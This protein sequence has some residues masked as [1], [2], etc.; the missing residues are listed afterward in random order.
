MSMVFTTDVRL[1]NAIEE[2]RCLG[3]KCTKARYQEFKE[4][5]T[6]ATTSFEEVQDLD[7]YITALTMHFSHDLN[8]GEV[9]TLGN[10]FS[11]ED[12]VK[13]GCNVTPAAFSL[14]QE[15][16]EQLVAEKDIDGM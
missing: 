16:L 8:R 12:L 3:I 7:E 4:V 11:E 15:A 13:V 14:V 9:V 2:G 6:H 10:V 5:F 1:R